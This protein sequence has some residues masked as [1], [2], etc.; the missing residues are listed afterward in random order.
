MVLKIFAYLNKVVLIFTSDIIEL[1]VSKIA[2]VVELVNK[3][4]M[5]LIKSF[6]K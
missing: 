6:R 1:S 2:K 5:E 3:K 4:K